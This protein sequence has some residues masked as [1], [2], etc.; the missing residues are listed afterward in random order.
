MS[1]VRFNQTAALL[2]QKAGGRGVDF[3]VGAA[4]NKTGALL[5][6]A[7]FDGTTAR[8]SRARVRTT[9]ERGRRA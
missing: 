6:T 8:G 3:G 1:L 5:V 4:A 9:F 7:S 2:G